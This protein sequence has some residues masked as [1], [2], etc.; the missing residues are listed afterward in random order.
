MRETPDETL[1]RLAED[2]ADCREPWTIFGG[3][4]LR[5]HGVVSGRIRDIDVLLAPV[6][7]ERM[8]TRHGL[9][10]RARGGTAHF[11][12][13]ILLHPPLGPTPVELMAGFEVRVAGRWLPVDI[14]DRLPIRHEGRFLP[15]ATLPELERL[16]R[17]FDRPKDRER[18][19]LVEAARSRAG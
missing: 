1:L 8:A 2:L 6:D 15:V 9:P 4:A 11:R 5:L 7:A 17:L 14:R 19:R 12:S 10:N 16:L 3:A 18:L 13:R